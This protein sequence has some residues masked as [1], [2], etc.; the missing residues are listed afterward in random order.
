MS[1]LGYWV[2]PQADLKEI[3]A[4]QNEDVVARFATDYE[5]SPEDA[6]EIF[7]EM[8]RWLYITAR[9][10]DANREM[11]AVPLFNEAYAIDMMWHT[12]ILFTQDYAE[13]CDKY[14]GTF[15][16]HQ[17]KTLKDTREWQ[18]RIKADPEGARRDRESN[19]RQVYEYLADEVGLEILAKWCEDFPNRFKHLTAEP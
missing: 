16:H 12:F 1:E 18:A 13:F 6:Q 14:F 3:L 19:L 2:K 8:K 9:R 15:I 17:P 5:V 10:R 11:A 7:I 4:Y